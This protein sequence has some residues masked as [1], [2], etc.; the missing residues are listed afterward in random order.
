MRSGIRLLRPIVGG[1]PIALPPVVGQFVQS[2]LSASARTGTTITASGTAHTMGSWASLIDPT[3]RPS[4]G[5]LVGVG[6]LHTS[7]TRTSFLLDVGVGPTG[8]GS[9]R[10]I[11]PFLDVGYALAN[12]NGAMSKCWYFPMYVESGARISARGQASVVSDTCVVQAHLYQA[13]LFPALVSRWKDYGTAA[14]SSNGTSVT[15]ASGSF[16]SWTNVGSTTSRAHNYWHVGL[17]GLTSTTLTA[18]GLLVE[19]GFTQ[20]GADRSIGVFA[21]AESNSEWIAGPINV[22][23]L[24]HPVPS[25]TQLRARIAA[26]GTS[27]HGV[28]IYAGD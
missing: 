23:P 5:I 20:D 12:S 21:F 6:E 13:P 9:E 8:G 27:A 4:Y 18:M 15:P 10:V 25:G 3:S 28:V 26:G 19:I 2:N 14:A 1:A 11:L 7:G 17:D 22:E 16:G 24:Y